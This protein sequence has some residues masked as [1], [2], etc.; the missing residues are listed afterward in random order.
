M[1][2]SNNSTKHLITIYWKD[3]K[4]VFGLENKRTLSCLFT[5]IIY[6]LLF[7]FKYNFK[8]LIQNEKSWKRLV[9]QPYKTDRKFSWWKNNTSIKS[10]EIMSKRYGCK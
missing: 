3:Q 8:H 9:Q 1:S 10:I 6:Y 5:D 4:Y 7:F 2:H